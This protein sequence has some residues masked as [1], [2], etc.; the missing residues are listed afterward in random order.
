MGSTKDARVLVVGAGGHARVCIEALLDGGMD[1]VGCVSADG[2]GAAGLPCPVLGRT[3]D[4][5]DVALAAAATHAFVA[6]GDNAARQALAG[7]CERASLPLVTAISRFA[8]VSSSARLGDGVVVLA[9][10]VVNAAAVVGRGVILNTRSSV[11]HD[12]VVADFAHISVGVSL[13]G[14][15]SIGARALVGIG[16]TVLPGLKV[17]DD[18][19]VGGGA[20]VVRSVPAGATVVGVPATVQS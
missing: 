9:G 3:A 10:A 14:S 13:G 20:V 6:V 4:L 17:G 16:S 19:V 15:V 5:A 2:N 18:A 1:V 7:E 8:M 11:D 12:N